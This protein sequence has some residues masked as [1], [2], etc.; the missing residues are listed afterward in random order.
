MG[1]QCNTHVM[2]S[3]VYTTCVVC[4]FVGF[5]NTQKGADL[6]LKMHYKKTHPNIKFHKGLND[7]SDIGNYDNSTGKLMDNVK[8]TNKNNK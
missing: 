6:I 3:S 7:Y 1:R 5:N 8:Y 2:K 4:G